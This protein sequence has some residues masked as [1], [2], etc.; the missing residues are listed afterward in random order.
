MQ[1]QLV[2]LTTGL[3][4]G[5]VM[6]EQVEKGEVEKEEGSGSSS[7]SDDSDD[8]VA[9]VLRDDVGRVTKTGRYVKSVLF[10]I[11]HPL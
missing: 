1:F 9:N 2:D 11:T 6:E 8:G 7:D 5:Y 4:E 10:A 3:K